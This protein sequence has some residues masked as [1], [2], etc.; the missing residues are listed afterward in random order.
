[1]GL[2]VKKNTTTWVPAKSIYVKIGVGTWKIVKK[3]YVKTTTSTWRI[4]WP[5]NGPQPII[6]PFFSTDSAGNNVYTNTYVRITN[7][8]NILYG[9]N[10]TWDNTGFTGTSYSYQVQSCDGL[11]TGGIVIPKDPTTNTALSGTYSTPVKIDLRTY[12]FNGITTPSQYSGRYLDFLISDNNTQGLTTSDVQSTNF[13]RIWVVNNSPSP[14]ATLM[15]PS[16]SFVPGTAITYVAAYDGTEAYCPDYTRTVVKWYKSTTNLT[17]TYG[18]LTPSIV[19]TYATYIS[20]DSSPTFTNSNNVWQVAS[21]YTT[22]TTTDPGN[23]FYAIDTEFNS[24]SD[25]A[26]NISGVSSTSQSPQLNNPPVL[27]TSPTL[28]ATTAAGYIGK[29][30]SFTVGSTITVN[31]GT[32]TPT[33]TKVFSGV[34]FNSTNSGLP[35]SWKVLYLT[36]SSTSSQSWFNDLQNTNHSFTLSGLVYDSTVTQYALAGQYLGYAVNAYNGNAMSLEADAASQLVYPA[37]NSQT[38]IS[39]TWTADN[40]ANVIWSSLYSS[41]YYQLSYSSSSSGPWTNIGTTQSSNA[42]TYS[43]SGLPSGSYYYSVI[44]YNADGVGIQGPAFGPYNSTPP[45][46]TPTFTYDYGQSYALGGFTA[47]YGNITVT[48]NK[49]TSITATIYRSGSTSWTTITNESA[50]SNSGTLWYSIYSNGYYYM[51]VTATNSH[52]S[53]SAYSIIA[54]TTEFFT[55]IPMGTSSQSVSV[56]TSS[57]YPTLSYIPANW[58]TYSP[59]TGDNATYKSNNASFEYY[60]STSSTTPANTVT[61]TNTGLSVGSYTSTNTY[62]DTAGTISPAT[63]YYYWIRGRNNDTYSGWQYMGSVLTPSPPVVSTQPTWTLLS[64]TANKVGATYRLNFGSWTGTPTSYLWQ[65]Y[66]NDVSGTV[67]VQDQTGTYSQGYYDWTVTVAKSNGAGGF[68][69]VGAFVYAINSVGT[70]T[71]AG[72]PSSLPITPLTPS[73]S[74]Y[75]TLS[76]SG[77]ALTNITFAGG[78]YTNYASKTTTLYAST[79]L[80]FS[81]SVANKGSTSPYQITNSDAQ[82]PAFYFAVCDAVLGIDGVTYYYWSGGF[83]GAAGTGAVT[84]TTSS[85]GAIL[86]YPPPF[87]INSYPTISGSGVYGATV[88]GSA[89][90]YSGYSSIS[91]TLIYLYSAASTNAYSSSTPGYSSTSHTWSTG[92]GNPPVTHVVMRDTVVGNDAVTRYIYSGGYSSTGT[93]TVS[94]TDGAGAIVAYLAT[95]TTPTLNSSY[96]STSGGFT[97]TIT[98][99][100]STASYTAAIGSYNSTTTPTATVSGSTVTVSNVSNG[101]YVYVS[102]TATKSGYNPSTSAQVF[103]Y[104]LSAPSAFTYYGYDSTVTPSWPSGAGISITGASNNIMTVNWNAASSAIT[105]ADQVFGVYNS[106]TLFNTGANRSDTW[107]YGSSGNETATV[108]AYNSSLTATIAWGASTGAQSYFYYYFVG[109]TAY[110]GYTTAT[111]ISFSVPAATTVTLNGIAAYSLPSGGGLGTGGTLQ[112]GY[113]STFTPTQKSTSAGSGTFF[114][115]YTAP[116][117]YP[118]ITMGSTTS[119][120]TAGATINWSQTNASYD[121]LNGS[122]YLGLATAYTFTGLAAG[123]TYSGTVTVYS[124]TGNTASA[125]Y[126]F[127]TAAAGVKPSAP[128]GLYGSNDYSPHG[129]H[130]YFTASATGTAPITYYFTVTKSTTLNGTYSAYSSS[131]TAGTSILVQATGYFK[132]SVYASNAYGSS[133]TVSTSTGVQFT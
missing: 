117:I 4:F 56:G 115:T 18:T 94:I 40:V 58:Q 57:L 64:G 100:D 118:T 43:Y 3:I 107:S 32:W 22:N 24:G 46:D 55:G 31:N 128:T 126:S 77:Q 127:T 109:A 88:T 67:I 132:C 7:A 106:S 10:G 72:Y 11:T 14:Q 45:P 6:Y 89:G 108:Y 105:Y 123:T 84:E 36:S 21:S 1:M 33:P 81:T 17:T 59:Y 101:A 130:F 13:W 75:P 27:V 9:N 38:I 129:G 53:T 131:S 30:N 120:T 79:S 51:Y 19:Q 98:N 82:S 26:G 113:T 69:T 2:F 73:V 71:A 93:N 28:T 63:T 23:Y 66:Y 35:S 114:L 34:A 61:P 110:S 52:G 41:S 74:S 25:Y 111:S 12:G 90:T 60:R 54:N 104:S 76:G 65:I 78:T 85:G 29:S 39:M 102:V 70:A 125:S 121:Y 112:S 86:S 44:A 83:T 47:Y 42:T 95:Q 50:S 37:P 62:V 103:G 15:I 48:A 122:T 92:D 87:T 80:S 91:S 96:T 49:A 68:Y 16:V 97:T 133:S 99:Y 124:T 20:T 116:P 5:D 8:G 119:I